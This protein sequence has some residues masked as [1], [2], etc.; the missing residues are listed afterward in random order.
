MSWLEYTGDAFFVISYL[1]LMALIWIVS[2]QNTK[3]AQ[4][5][6]LLEKKIGDVILYLHVTD[7]TGGTIRNAIDDLT[8]TMLNDRK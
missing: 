7:A 2:R 6:F 5:N 8:E 4:R 1:S 3:L